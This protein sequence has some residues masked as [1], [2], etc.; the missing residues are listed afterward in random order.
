LLACQMQDTHD[1]HAKSAGPNGSAGTNDWR[2][3]EQGILEDHVQLTFSDRFIRAG[4][5][6]FSPDNSKIFF[7]AVEQPPAGQTADEFYAMFVADVKR[8]A[9]SGNITG[10]D[11][12]KRL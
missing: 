3:A 4:E 2:V 10:I 11:Q 7:Q 6:Y 1:E 5:S 8:D 12:I 9:K